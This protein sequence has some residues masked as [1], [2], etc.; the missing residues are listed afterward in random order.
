MEI[1]PV[2]NSRKPDY[3][4]IELFVQYPELLSRHIP[5]N[6]LK[7]KFVVTSLVVFLLSGC[8]TDTTGKSKKVEIVDSLRSRNLNDD[9]FIEATP[10]S[11]VINIAPIFVHGEG[12][13][14]IGCVVM[15]PPVFMSEDEAVKIILDKLAAEGYYFT[16]KNSPIFSF[17][18]LPIANGCRKAKG[19]VKIELKMDACNPTSEWVI[20]LITVGEFS[21]F[22]NGDVCLSTA[23]N[24]ETKHAA[25]IINEQLKI[26]QKTNAVVFYEPLPAV[27]F[28]EW[29]K[30]REL[31]EIEA[32]KLLLAQVD[33]FINWLKKNNIKIY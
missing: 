11:K 1:K 29:E 32:K 21:K 2:N 17:E 31:A 23:Y 10:Q 12:S 16:R 6:W 28:W 18:V 5:S 8:G 22:R 14:G 4:T 20:K 25:E 30:G 33:D 9:K 7:N 13:G 15:S 19:S 26:Q 3:P 24:F 27:E